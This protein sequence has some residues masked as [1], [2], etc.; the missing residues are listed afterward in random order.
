MIPSLAGGGAQRTVLKISGGLAER[1]H[2][3][4]IVL[5]APR[6]AYPDEVPESSRLIF[7]CGR[8]QWARCTKADIPAGAIWRSERVSSARLVGL[9]AGILHDFPTG[10]TVLLRRVALDRALRLANYVELERPD[11]LF[12]NLTPAEYPAFFAR[13]LAKPQDFPPIVPVVRNVAKKGARHTKRRQMLF[14]EAAHVVAVSRGVA[15][16]VSQALL[17]PPEKVA[18]IYNPTFTPD[19]ARRAEAEAPHEWFDEGS[20]PVVLGAGRL[21]PQKDFG[22]LIEAFRRMSAARACR[23][24]ILGEGP[25][26]QQLE[27]Q[28]RALGLEDR[29]SLPGWTENPYAFMSRASLFVLS[30]RH[31]GFPGVLVEALA[32]G[33]QAVS[34]DCPAGPSEILDDADLL[35]PVGN[36]EELSRVMLQALDRPVDKP[37]LRSRAAS[38]SVE[39]AVEKYEMLISRIAAQSRF[40][41]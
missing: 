36:P 34:T 18:P 20:P 15:D 29:V 1:G 25:L 12:A 22:T 9:V 19:I 30:S 28:I 31:E 40:D 33:C 8:A 23:L 35:A 39:R 16:N 32:C 14:P 4:D 17:V 21:V 3:V 10:A 38:F 41:E 11:I 7:L 24:I 26:R 6:V 2:S 27:R 5:F 37:A 13:R